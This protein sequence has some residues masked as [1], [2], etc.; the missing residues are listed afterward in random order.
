[1]SFILKFSGSIFGVGSTKS[2]ALMWRTTRGGGGGGG[3]TLVVPMDG[4]SASSCTTI[5]SSAEPGAEVME[6]AAAAAAGAE[7]ME[8]AAAAGW[9]MSVLLL[10]VPKCWMVLVS[11]FCTWYSRL[12]HRL[13]M[14]LHEASAI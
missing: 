11:K 12:W 3:G 1:M 5:G 7:V 4:A 2:S 6:G 8:G 10:L 13:N 14:Y 9:S